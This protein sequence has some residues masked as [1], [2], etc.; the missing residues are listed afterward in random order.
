MREGKP[1]IIGID[2]GTTTGIA[3]FDLDGKLLLIKSGK[4]L[5]K[6]GISRIVSDAGNP[7]I[8]SSD[9]KPTPRA[10]QNVA[11]IFSARIIEPG[12]TFSRKEKHETARGYMKLHGRV[13]ANRHERDA[14]VSGI[15][16]WK[17]VR[18]IVDRMN[19]RLRKARVTDSSVRHRIMVEVLL[20]KNSIDS[21]I[22]R[23]A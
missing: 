8:V 13:W 11:T 6:S 12:E 20:G 18:Q 16:A 22:K 15:Y 3:V 9:I 7:I 19:S 17:Q 4:N 14:L 23:H 21:A 1:L 10:V 5:A 2:P